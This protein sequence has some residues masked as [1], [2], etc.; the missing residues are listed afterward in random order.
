MTNPIENTLDKTIEYLHYL[1]ESGVQYLNGQPHHQEAKKLTTT[2]KQQAATT[3][4]TSDNKPALTAI[5]EEVANCTKCP[6]HK[7]RTKTVPGVGSPQAQI[8][9]IGEGPGHDEDLQGE[10]FVGPAG[11]ILTRLINKMGYQREDIYIANIVK[12]RPTVDYAM[13]KDRPPSVEEMATCLPYLKRQIATLKPKVIVCLGNTA[14]EGLFGE[15][16]ITKIRGQWRSYEGIP[17]MPTYHPSY[18]LRQGGEN[19]EAYWEVWRD[20]QAVQEK[21]AAL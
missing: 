17:A 5:A 21:L 20:M 6:L 19:K 9:F 11:R 1:Q 16:G 18:L 10:P 3:P 7:T 13:I 12:C 2:D 14:L 4:T 8:M 15:R